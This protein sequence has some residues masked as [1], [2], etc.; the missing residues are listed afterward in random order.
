MM[1]EILKPIRAGVGASGIFT[2]IILVIA[3]V[4]RLEQR[5]LLFGAIEAV[6]ALSSVV[7]SLLGTSNYCHQVYAQC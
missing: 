1:N 3:Q 2:S 6:F 7:G 4:T 5:P